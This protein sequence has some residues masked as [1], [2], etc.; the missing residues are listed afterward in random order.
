L[1]I[2]EKIG[3]FNE[4][5]I[6]IQQLIEL[7]RYLSVLYVEDDAAVRENTQELLS[8]YMDN[9]DVAVD[10]EDGLDKYSNYFKST[11]LHYDLVI[12]DI[13][14]PNLNGIEMSKEVL[15]MN[16]DQVIIVLSAY[17]DSSRLIDLINLGINQFVMK[18]LDIEHFEKILFK[19]SKYIH[20]NK[21]SRDYN[22]QLELEVAQRTKVLED[23]MYTDEL[24]GLYN[25]FGL[26]NELEKKESNILFVVDIDNFKT[27]NEVYGIEEGNKIIIKFSEY[28]QKLQ[29][30]Y[31]YQVFRL[32]GDQFALLYE[33][34]LIEND[35]FVDEVDRVLFE[36][37][38][39]K[40][41]IELSNVTISL[42]A[43]IGIALLQENSLNKAMMALAHSKSNNIPY[44]VYSAKIDRKKEFENT[45]YWIEEIKKALDT[46]SIVP[47]FQP[48]VDRDNQV[49]KYEV[50][51]RLVQTLED[52][53]QKVV[54]PFFFLETAMKSKLYFALT[55]RM[56]TQSFEAMA[57]KK[58]DF[59]LN[60]TFEDMNNRSL[61]EFLERLIV[62]YAVGDRLILEV[63]ESQNIKNSDAIQELLRSFRMYGVRI[64]IDDFGS[65]YSNFEN[66]LMIEPDF[67]KIDGSLIKNIDHDEKSL[68]LTKAIVGF[69]HQMGIKVVAEYIYNEKIYTIANNLDVDEFQGYYFSE[70]L[71]R[72][73]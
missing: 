11:S 73:H 55:E 43:T 3:K 36:I 54:S 12:T 5:M 39:E 10:G 27:Y 68:T 9:I 63:V 48:I 46:S 2:I 53:T 44:T 66:I 60:L 45:I 40:F 56:I 18:P 14:M 30:K 72:P 59:S 21:V 20:D 33:N 42:T 65:G 70:P 22:K 15:M 16:P 69:S 28:L 58:E 67:I 52:G 25:R 57:H 4:N 24:T 51:M 37:K 13:N 35:A 62:D 32:G 71:E 64:A 29:D 7:S 38:Q 17:N 26:L 49:I 1:T 34:R 23:R 61:M 19:A 41:L 6:D 31:N 47:Y 8:D 50:L